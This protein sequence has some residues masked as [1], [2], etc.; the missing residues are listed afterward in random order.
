MKILALAFKEL[1]VLLRDR[2]AWLLM[3]A[4][5]LA[6]TAVMGFA[7]SGLQT[8]AGLPAIP[9][10][11][12]NQDEGVLGQTLVDWL[13]SAELSD[14]LAPTLAADAGAARRRVDE[15]TA[16]A[17]VI[18]PPDLT[19]SVLT[20]AGTVS[21]EVYANPART[22]GAGVVKSIVARFAQ[23]V[24]AAAASTEVTVT[25]LVQSGRLAPEQA[26]AFAAEFGQRAAAAAV[27]RELVSV[28]LQTT[29]DTAEPDFNYMA[30]YAPSM[31]IMFLMFAMVTAAR[32]WLTEQELGTL[33]RLRAAPARPFEL[34]GGKILGIVGG[35][36]LQMAVLILATHYLLGVEWGQPL[37]VAVLVMLVVLALAALGLA[38]A[39]FLRTAGQVSAVGGAG[40]MIL[41]AV[42]GNFAPRL[43]MP[44]WLRGLG[45]L[46][47]NAWGLEGFLKLAAGATLADLTTEIAVLTAITGVFFGLAVWGLQ[48]FVR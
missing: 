31:A 6:L 12:V 7:F 39:A 8:G 24:A 46:C 16:A 19:E 30:Y 20:S 21:I 36:V 13:T 23:V 25:Q 1:Q 40:V 47:P 33:A 18:I 35:G 2:V 29:R 28:N 44:V 43:A 4:A 14:L 38:L 3:V 22:V 11:V 26:A 5:P 9:V 41:S 10:V 48:K 42:G 37:A 17:A 34:L 27:A 45:Y 32:T 15:D